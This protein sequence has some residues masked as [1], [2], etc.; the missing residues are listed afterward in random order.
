[1]IVDWRLTIVDLWNRFVLS[2]YALIELKRDK[3]LLVIGVL[4]QISWQKGTRYPKDSDLSQVRQQG[5]RCQVSGSADRLMLSTAHSKPQ[6]RMTCYG[7]DTRYFSSA[8]TL[9]SRSILRFQPKD[10]QLKESL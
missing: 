4:L 8:E 5:F 1:M 3:L 10:S 7:E 2:C 6:S 9:L